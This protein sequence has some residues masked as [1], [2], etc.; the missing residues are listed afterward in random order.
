MIAKYWINSVNVVCSI[1]WLKLLSAPRTSFGNGLFG[2]DLIW[3]LFCLI[4]WVFCLDSCLI[5]SFIAFDWVW[6]CWIYFFA[7]FIS[8]YLLFPHTSYL[9]YILLHE[10]FQFYL[11]NVFILNYWGKSWECQWTAVTW[12]V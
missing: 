10:V 9:F 1:I 8:Y 6:L 5:L 11:E 2:L 3:V 4:W 12:W 7:I